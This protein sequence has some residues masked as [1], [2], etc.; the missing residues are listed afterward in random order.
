[1]SVDIAFVREKIRQEGFFP[2]LARKL[3]RIIYNARFSLHARFVNKRDPFEI[4]KLQNRYGYFRCGDI[5]KPTGYNEGLGGDLHEIYLKIIQPYINSEICALDIGAGRGG[6]TKPML[7]A[8]EVWAL[9]AQPRWMCRIDEFLGYPK[10][11]TFIKVKDFLCDDLPDNH[12]DYCLSM[13]TFYLLTQEQQAEYFKNL[14][15][16]MK[17]GANGFIMIADFEKYKNYIGHYPEISSDVNQWKYNTA[18]ISERALKSYGWEVIS[19]DV[20]LLKRD[21]IIHFRKP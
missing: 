1:M 17:H 20:G 14:F 8:K 19:R 16:K 10:N 5:T 21:A 7:L 3:K 2:L 13:A 12:F 15:P 18:E 4:A 11:F 9:E 6:F